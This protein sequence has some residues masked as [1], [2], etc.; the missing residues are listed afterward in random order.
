MEVDLPRLPE[1]VGLHEVT[2]VVNMK[3]VLDGVVLQ[4]CYEAGDIDGH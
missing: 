1:R 3:T 2:L 4:V